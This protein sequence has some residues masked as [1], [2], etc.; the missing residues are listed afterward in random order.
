MTETIKSLAK[1]ASMPFS[2]AVSIA[3]QFPQSNIFYVCYLCLILIYSIYS[4]LFCLACDHF[5]YREKLMRLSYVLLFYKTT[6]GERLTGMLLNFNIAI[7]FK[8][9]LSRFSTLKCTFQNHFQDSLTCNGGNVTP[10]H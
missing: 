1:K 3:L 4:N 6:P 10:V 2:A 9:A 7:T 8:A 5:I